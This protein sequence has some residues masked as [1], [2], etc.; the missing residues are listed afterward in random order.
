MVLTRIIVVLQRLFARLWWMGGGM[1]PQRTR[2]IAQTAC[3]GLF[4]WS[5]TLHSVMTL[6]LLSILLQ[7]SHRKSL[8][9]SV[10]FFID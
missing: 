3:L 9:T 1:E 8:D 4:S 7:S 2:T 5:S 6:G 10:L